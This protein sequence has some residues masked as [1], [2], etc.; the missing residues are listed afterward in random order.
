MTE[1]HDVRTEN[2]GHYAWAGW[3]AIISA[4]LLVPEI[5]L[6]LALKLIGSELEMLVTPIHAVNLVI[7]VYVLWILRHLLNRRFEFHAADVLITM[8]IVINLVSFII[9]LVDFTSAFVGL[10]SGAEFNVSVVT[11]VVF[12]LYCLVNVAFAV[13][14]L[15]LKDDLYGLLKPYAYTTIVSSGLGA[16]VV[17]APIGLFVAVVALVILGMIFLRAKR[18][19]EIL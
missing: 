16:T 8:L 17:L 14:L 10:P 13:V 9:G 15:R 6:A 19:A 12:V 1:S 18:E 2:Y 5:V 7:G 11:L 4:V 3:L